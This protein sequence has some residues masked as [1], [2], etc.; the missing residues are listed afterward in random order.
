MTYE[1]VFVQLRLPPFF[2]LPL[3]VVVQLLLVWAKAGAMVATANRQIVASNKAFI[4]FPRQVFVR[5]RD[6]TVTR[7]GCKGADENCRGACGRDRRLG[8][9]GLLRGFV[10]PA[11]LLRS[12]PRRRESS[13]WQKLDPLRP[14][15]CLADF[16]GDERLRN[17]APYSAARCATVG[18]TLAT[19][20]WLTSR[21]D[22]PLRS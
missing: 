1:H 12:F 6:H 10:R 4:G 14:N 2:A 17:C 13:T 3:Q 7:G 16:R 21:L 11:S 20:V 18:A 22:Q 8:A 9:R 19:V 15:T 5:G